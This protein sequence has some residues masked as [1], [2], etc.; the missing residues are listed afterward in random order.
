M[1]A[2]ESEQ[3]KRLADA[4]RYRQGEYS[5]QPNDYTRGELQKSMRELA[6]YAAA[7]SR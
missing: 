7:V 1:S 4:Y 3:M 6:D 5:Y 2:R